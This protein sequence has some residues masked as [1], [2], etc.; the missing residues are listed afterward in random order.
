MVGVSKKMIVN[1]NYSTQ[2]NNRNKIQQQNF[3]DAFTPVVAAATFIE[4]NGFTAEFFLEDAFGMAGPRTGQGLFRNKEELG[5]LNYK[6]AREEAV[7]EALSPIAIF[8]FPA[9]VIATFALLKGRSAK[10][11]VGILDAFKPVMHR[12]SSSITHVGD[13]KSV[14][15]AFIENFVKT[16]FKGF[17]REAEQIDKLKG[18]L[19]NF[20]DGKIK[21]KAAIKEAEEALATLNKAN[22]KFFDDTSKIAIEGKTLNISEVVPSIANYL[23]HF[24]KKVAESSQPMGDFIE[25][26]H[27]KAAKTRKMATIAAIASFALFSLIIPKLYQ[28]DKKFPGLD[29]LDTDSFERNKPVSERRSV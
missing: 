3:G 17:D 28:T 13:S 11:P 12:A 1:N 26:F 27:E 15:E 4:N 9:A 10:V 24:T 14:K 18:V 19:S 5:H 2:M 25:K 23:T 7:R 6:A 16:A 21:E 20:A 8:L 29:G 22:G